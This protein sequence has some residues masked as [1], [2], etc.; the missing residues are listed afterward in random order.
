MDGR[1]G[2]VKSALAAGRQ[3][4]KIN[5]R[6]GDGK[7]GQLNRRIDNSAFG[8]RLGLGAGAARATEQYNE[9]YEKRVKEGGTLLQARMSHDQIMDAARTGKGS[10]GKALTAHERDAAIRYTMDRGNFNERRRVVEGVG[11]MT[12][13][14]RKSL[15]SGLRAKGDARVYGNSAVAA[16]EATHLQGKTG[17]SAADADAEL[18][19]GIVRKVNDGELSVETIAKDHRVAKAVADATPGAKTDAR[20]RLREGVE[21]YQRENAQDWSKLDDATKMYMSAI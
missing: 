1:L 3:R 14:Q 15:G 16:I 19:D 13:D 10:D 20:D 11:D 21:R 6:V 4:R 12:R 17:M 5:R 2:E 9:D 7:F 18:S 8:R